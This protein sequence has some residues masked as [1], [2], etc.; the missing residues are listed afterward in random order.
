MAFE[1]KMVMKKLILAALAASVVATPALAA[2]GYG[3]AR[4]DRMVV[5]YNDHGP[6][7][8]MSAKRFARQQPHRVQ[9]RKWQKGQRFDRHYARDYRVVQNYRANHRLYAPPRGYQWVQSGNDAVLVALAS[10]LIGAI[11]GGAF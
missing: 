8:G 10:G 4:S 3:P 7:R 2:P 5:N 6:Q 11:I 9:Y 1:R